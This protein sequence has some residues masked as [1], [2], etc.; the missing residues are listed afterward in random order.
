MED[1]IKRGPRGVVAVR[2]V[3]EDNPVVSFEKLKSSVN[4]HL[5]KEE[6]Y[7]VI[8]YLI[9]NEE[10]TVN[11]G[12]KDCFPKSPIYKTKDEVPLHTVIN[13]NYY[14]NEEC[15]IPLYVAE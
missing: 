8:R 11:F 2:K 10:L 9:D 4:I 13:D 15:I 1:F 12:L 6:L 7:A 3:L 14:I 5:D